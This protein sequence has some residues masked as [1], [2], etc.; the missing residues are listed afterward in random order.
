MFVSTLIRL[1]TFAALCMFA[2][3]LPVASYAGDVV[4]KWVDEN[5]VTHYSQT[6][7]PEGAVTE[8]LQK[9]RFV[10]YET[11]EPEEE[12]DYYSVIN[13]ANRLRASRLELEKHRDQRKLARATAAGQLQQNQLP[14][15]ELYRNDN[16]Y[17]PVYPVYSGSHG[18][19]HGADKHLP[20]KSHKFGHGKHDPRHPANG[21][22]ENFGVHASFGKRS[23][24]R[25][26]R[27]FHKRHG[28]LGI[29]VHQTQ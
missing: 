26:G 23:Q 19:R 25:L 28:G 3:C 20:H 7:P 15:D 8:D 29:D 24:G 17:Y 27:G 4:L 6:P 21:K 2:W 10:S 22:R 12:D 9:L 5:G 13:Q 1:T 11:E 18:F 14:Q 16:V